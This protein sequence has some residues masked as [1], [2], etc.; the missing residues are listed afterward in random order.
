MA[1]VRIFSSLQARIMRTAISPRL[2]T[3]I[4]SNIELFLGRPDF[5]E[6]LT[7]L[8]RFGIFDEQLSDHPAHLGLNFVHHFHRLDDADNGIRVHFGA[9]FHVVD[10]FGRG[11]SVKSSNHWGSYFD[12]IG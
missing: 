10:R 6:R 11:R 1:T 2:A 5:K 3:S 9:Y 12:L 8:D 4:F 7:K